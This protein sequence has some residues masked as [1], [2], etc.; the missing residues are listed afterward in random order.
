[1][2]IL[3]GKIGKTIKFKNLHINTGDDSS[4]ILFS[5]MARM[6][7]EHNFYFCGPNDLKKLSKEEYNYIF[8]NGNVYSIYVNPNRPDPNDKDILNWDSLTDHIRKENIKFDFAILFTG[9]VG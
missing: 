8:P 2:N 6:L 3:I 4:M 7:P 1:M 5:T 9:Y